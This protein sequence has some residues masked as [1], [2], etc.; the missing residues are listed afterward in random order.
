[1]KFYFCFIVNGL[2]C[3]YLHGLYYNL[4]VS[5]VISC[6]VQD[7]EFF[8]EPAKKSLVVCYQLDVNLRLS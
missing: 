5:A 3:C 1:M 4:Y 6:R 7:N 8:Q 2:A